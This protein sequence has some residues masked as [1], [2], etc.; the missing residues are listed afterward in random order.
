[1]KAFNLDGDDLLIFT[2][3]IYELRLRLKIKMAKH[4]LICC[5]SIWVANAETVLGADVSVMVWVIFS[6]KSLSFHGSFQY[7]TFTALN[8]VKHLVGCGITKYSLL[9]CNSVY[10][11]FFFI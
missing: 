8:P 2:T 5:V 10:V 3:V 11:F 7:F 1:M 9:L 6:S 4:Q